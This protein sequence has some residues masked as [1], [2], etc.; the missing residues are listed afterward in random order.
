MRFDIFFKDA[1][2]AV[3]R[4]LRDWRFTSAAV[5]ILALAIGAN[6]AIFSVVNAALL[7]PQGFPDLDRLVDIYQNARDG[8]GPELTSWPA[9]RDIAAY[10]DVFAGLTAV[11]IPVPAQY[12]DQG[13]VRSGI[14]EYTTST[15]PSVLRLQPSLGRWF[16]ADEDARG[17]DVV[18]II[19]HQTWTREFGATIVARTSLDAA[20][21]LGTMQRELRELNASLPVLSVKTMT[22]HLDRS[23]AGARGATTFLGV[24][25]AVGAC[26]AGIGLYAVVAFA[27]ARR[28]REIGIRM[29]LGAQRR[30]V[31]GSVAREVGILMGVGTGVGLALSTIGMLI[32]RSVGL[33][34]DTV[35]FYY[36]VNFDPLALLLIA[37]FIGIVGLAAAFVPARRAARMSPLTALRYD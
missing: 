20:A 22:Q 19:G 21:L 32:L 4:L 14:V 29:A 12:R 28:S 3:R 8:S 27:V 17:A 15:Y 33:S 9:F 35:H 31:V 7:R 25:G 13:S 37:A 30:Q 23:L 5:L 1:R 11:G 16:N 26:L 2:D 18:G 24:P 6:T 34:S 10:T 36:T